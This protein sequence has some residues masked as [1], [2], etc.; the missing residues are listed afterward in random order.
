MIRDAVLTLA[1][2]QAV[3]T[4]WQ[5]E[6]KAGLLTQFNFVLENDTLRQ[7]REDKKEPAKKEHDFDLDDFE[8]SDGSSSDEPE[9][10]NFT[11]FILICIY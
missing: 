9:V 5:K 1:N 11:H 8:E 10:S 4:F 3:V 7:L 6:M 2:L